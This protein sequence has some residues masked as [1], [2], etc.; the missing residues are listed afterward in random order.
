[1]LNCGHRGFGFRNLGPTYNN[2]HKVSWLIKS[3]LRFLLFEDNKLRIVA[4]PTAYQIILISVGEGN[5]LAQEPNCF[6]LLHAG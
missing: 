2:R 1:M 3:L 6:F 4:F 5:D